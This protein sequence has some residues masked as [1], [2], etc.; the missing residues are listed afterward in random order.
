MA[1]RVS[2]EDGLSNFNMRE[3]RELILN[4]YQLSESLCYLRKRRYRYHWIVIS[5]DDKYSCDMVQNVHHH[6][7]LWYRTNTRSVKYSRYFSN[8]P[9]VKHIHRVSLKMDWPFIKIFKHGGLK[10]RVE[11]LLNPVVG[12]SLGVNWL[13]SHFSFPMR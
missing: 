12:V 13:K 2:G 9:F 8:Q 7:F 11:R 10:K 3:V 6:L 4:K 1:A 5:H